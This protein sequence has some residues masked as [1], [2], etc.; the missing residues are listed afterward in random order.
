MTAPQNTRTTGFPR[1]TRCCIAIG[2]PERCLPVSHETAPYSSA[3]DGVIFSGHHRQ[4]KETKQRHR[5]SFR[6][7]AAKSLIT[8]IAQVR[9]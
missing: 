5:G 1:C 3:F 4:N 2:D 7:F 8:A 6:I 9:F